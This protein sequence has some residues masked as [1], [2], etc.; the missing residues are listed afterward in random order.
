MTVAIIPARGGS[1][2]IPGK[3]LKEICGV[4]LVV[5]SIQ[6]ALGSR[7]VEK[8][9]VSTDD[10]DIGHVSMRAGADIVWRPSDIS[11]DTAPSEDALLHVLNT[12]KD[13]GEEPPELVVF[14]Q[15]TSPIRRSEDIDGAI[16]HLRDGGFDS[17]FSVS[18]AHG[19]VWEVRDDCP[20][21]LTYE[22]ASRP[23]RQEF[24]ERVMENGSIYVFKPS[25]LH[26]CKARTGGKIGVYRMGFLE[27]LQVDEQEDL[28]LA[29]W[30]LE[31]WPYHQSGSVFRCRRDRYQ[32]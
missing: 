22:P 2:G 4:P 27:A 21:P 28:D 10:P 24:G 8:V 6:H 13:M 11:G 31:H 29:E 5:H 12:I 9:I 3:N 18:P 17:V 1:K 19:F 16:R 30:I 23:M 32:P 26:E 14:L 15:A 25:I 20:V 7:F